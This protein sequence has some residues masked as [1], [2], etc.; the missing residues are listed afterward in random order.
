MNVCHTCGYLEQRKDQCP[1]NP[2]NKEGFGSMQ[3]GKATYSDSNGEVWVSTGVGVT[4]ASPPAR[5]KN[6]GC[7]LIAALL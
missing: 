7:I 2:K 1:Q 5:V 3:Q 6:L 4:L